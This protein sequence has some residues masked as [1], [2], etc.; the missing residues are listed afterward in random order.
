MSLQFLLVLILRRFEPRFLS[1]LETNFEIYIVLR[2]H[3]NAAEFVSPLT[4]ETLCKNKV[5]S[6]LFDLNKDTYESL[7]KQGISA[8]DIRKGE[9]NL[10][11]VAHQTP[12]AKEYGL[13]WAMQL[14]FEGK[15]RWVAFPMECWVGVLRDEE[16][17]E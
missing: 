16:D 11:L 13:S 4:F 3:K 15:L 2:Y 9:K 17:E 14:H 8:E 6:D 12:G 10:R 5:V 7:L 1:Y